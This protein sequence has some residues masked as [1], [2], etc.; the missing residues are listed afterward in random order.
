MTRTSMGEPAMRLRDALR[1]PAASTRLQAA[2]TAGSTPTPEYVEVLVERCAIEPD[3]FVRDMLTW[4]LIRHDS[5]AVIERLLPELDSEVPQA[6]AQALH[7]LS[8]IGDPDIWTAVTPALLQDDDEEV[9]RAAWRTSAGLVPGGRDAE[10]LAET[11]STQF[12]R[13]GRDLQLSLSRAFVALGDGAV[14]VVER[15]KSA[16]D[17]G[18]R[19]HA[20]ATERLMQDPYLGFDAAIAEARRIVALREAPVVEPVMEP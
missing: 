4:A 1:T 16:P 10:G 9:A 12:D 5:S 7:T 8:K 3:F 11:L 18:V 14:A 15:A 20:A 17:A 2:L 13:G 19:T 6:R